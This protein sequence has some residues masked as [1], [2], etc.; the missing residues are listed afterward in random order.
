MVL[1]ELT[2]IGASPAARA[3]LASVAKRSAPAISP[4]SLAAVSGPKPGSESSCGAIWATSWAISASSA[5]IVC[6]EFAQAPQLVAGDPDAHRLLGARQA[7][8]D[9]GA[10]LGREQRAAGQRELGPEIVQVPLERVVEPD[11]LADQALAVIDEQPQVE[12]GPV[13]VRGRQRVEAF[14]QRRAGD[15][16]R[17]DAVGLPARPGRAARVGHQLRRHPQ[18]PL[19]AGD[20]KPLKAS[21]ATC[22]QS[23]SAQTRSPSRLARPDQQRREAARARPATVFSPRSSPVAA[24]TAAI[25]CERL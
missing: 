21:P 10:P 20:Q 7:P 23:S 2:G 5:L 18:H 14:A 24:E 13:Q 1:P 3:S 6:G 12:L 15:R 19:A 16:D 9:P 17:V 22:R 8:A 4:T 25:V 11:P